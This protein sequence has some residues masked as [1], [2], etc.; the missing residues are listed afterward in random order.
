MPSSAAGKLPE[1]ER[2][3]TTAEIAA[4]LHEKAIEQL[5]QAIQAIGAGD[6]EKRCNAT[7]AAVEMIATLH[8]ALEFDVKNETVDRMGAVYRFV[9][10]SLFRVN[11]QDDDGLAAQ[12]IEV[13]RPLADAWRLL[14]EAGD[15]L[16]PAML[17]TG[18]I[19]E[20]DK[21]SKTAEAASL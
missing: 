15:E 1:P 14:A 17:D 7:N 10:A 5:A 13:L 21:A 2:T 8:M 18:L 3:M 12:I 6:I 20:L 11:L 4:S 19:G 16:S 9:L